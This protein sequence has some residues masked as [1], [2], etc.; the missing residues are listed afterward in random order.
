MIMWDMHDH[1]TKEQA[2]ENKEKQDAASTN[3]A[4]HWAAR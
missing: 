2:K 1:T 3:C 4:R